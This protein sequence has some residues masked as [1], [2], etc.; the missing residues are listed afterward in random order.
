[1]NPKIEKKLLDFDPG[2][3]YFKYE[4]P[5]GN[6]EITKEENHILGRGNFGIFCNISYAN[7]IDN[8]QLSLSFSFSF[9]LLSL[10]LSLSLSLFLFLSLSYY[11]GTVYKGCLFGTTVA[12]KILDSSASSSTSS[13]V[14]SHV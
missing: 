1:V 2:S 7:F 10:S 9:F 8:L 12:V 13:Q 5:E 6:L 11:L 4:I 14:P 3:K